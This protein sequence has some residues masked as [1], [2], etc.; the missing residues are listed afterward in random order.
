M[1]SRPIDRRTVLRGALVGAAGLLGLTGCDEDST[2]TPTQTPTGPTART[3]PTA[4]DWRA[5]G[6]DLEGTLL[7]PEDQEEFEVATQLHDPRWD[8]L[9]PHGV[10]EVAS[11]EDVTTALA[12]ATR[13]GLP[14]R[15]R[16]GGHSLVGASTV[17]SGL[18]VSTTALNQVAYDAG[19]QQATIGA[20]TQ[21]IDMYAELDGDGR[22]VPSGSC[23]TV[24]LSGLTMGG[25]IGA[26]MRA[27]GLTCDAVRAATVVTADGRIHQVAQD[28][29]PDLFWALRGGGGGNVG[30]V[31]SWVLA[32]SAATP[33]GLGI[34]TW[35]TS[36][37]AAVIRACQ[38][39]AETA[40][41]SEYLGVH[42]RAVASGAEVLTVVIS[43]TGDARP[44][45]TTLEGAVGVSPASASYASHPHLD[46][47]EVLA[48]CPD[49]GVDRCHTP[50]RGV[51]ERHSRVSGSDVLAGVLPTSAAQALV[52]VVDQYG[53]AGGVGTLLIDVLGGAV[54]DIGVA[55]S[56]FPW[57]DAS[58][59]V[60]WYVATDSSRSSNDPARRWVTAGHAALGRASQGGYVNYIEPQRDISTYYGPNYDRLRRVRSRYDPNGVFDSPW[61]VPRA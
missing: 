26:E 29:E 2:T 40:A 39:R 25:G 4:D 23:P 14:V 19:S 30:I 45:A 6:A 61:T 44:E 22:T 56:A 33:I 43:L 15:A 49:S 13:F 9:R 50:P 37:G 34:L 57:R 24:G 53:R 58:A 21:L 12:F 17:R 59:I 32:T 16:S 52:D 27:Y 10:V 48:G 5:L 31:T 36:A 46:G 38:Q 54:G 18:V 20:G 47:V 1:T 41:P 51:L 11:A 60:Q 7:R 28:R 42:V 3:G 55:D 35:P 8:D